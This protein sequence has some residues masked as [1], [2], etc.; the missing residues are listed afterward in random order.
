[1]GDSKKQSKPYKLSPLYYREKGKIYKMAKVSEKAH[2]KTESGHPLT[3][4]EEKF[5]EEYVKTNNL[6]QSVIEA[7]YNV[8]APA[9][10][11][12]KLVN[13]DY[14]AEEIKF[15]LNSLK[16][17]KIADA[18]E[19]MEYFSAVMRGEITDQFGLE[20]SLSE[21]TKAAQELAKRQIDIPNKLEAK[22]E[23]PEIKISL[24]WDRP[25]RPKTVSEVLAESGNPI[26]TPSIS[27][28]IANIEDDKK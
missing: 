21:R 15:R 2:L 12:Q 4:K 14:I 5:I 7:G 23:V 1:M 10:Y 24:N 18:K 20:A 11:G 3:P 27:D 19:I 26:I 25:D 17:E 8:K 6:M 22:K 28:L 9:Q 16:N 13:K